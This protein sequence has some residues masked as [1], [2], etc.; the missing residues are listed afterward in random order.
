LAAYVIS[1]GGTDVSAHAQAAG[2][3]TA[4]SPV[5]AVAATGERAPQ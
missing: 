5:E 4:A 1:L 3:P 2:A